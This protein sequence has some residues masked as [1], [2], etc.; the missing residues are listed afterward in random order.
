MRPRVSRVAAG[1]LGRPGRRLRG[2]LRRRG[3]RVLARQRPDATGG[4]ELPRGRRRAGHASSTARCS[5]GCAHELRSSTSTRRSGRTASPSAWSAGSATSCAPRPWALPVDRTVRGIRDAAWLRVD[6]VPRVRPRGARGA[7]C[8]RSATRR[9]RWRRETRGGCSNASRDCPA[10]RPRSLPTARR[11]W[12]YPDAEYLAMIEACQARDRRGRCLP[13]VPDHRGDACTVTPDPV[14]T[15]LALRASAPR[16][17]ARCCA[18]ARS[19]C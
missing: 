12:A 13:A 14:A 11:T 17:T 18:P 1:T 16:T 7:G 8:S 2:G 6:R 10:H 19:R 5:T 9:R 3:C 15:Y 4:H